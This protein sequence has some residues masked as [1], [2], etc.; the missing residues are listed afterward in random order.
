[1]KIA[2]IGA[3]GFIGSRLTEWL[4][5]REKAVVKPVVRSFSSLARLAKFDLNWSIASAD[6]EEVLT[7]ALRGCDV[8]VQAVMGQLNLIEESIA[9]TYKACVNAKVK[10]LVYLSSASVHGQNPPSATDEKSILVD[11][12]SIAYNNCKVRAERLLQK[13]AKNGET[14]IVILRPGIVFGPRDRW[15]SGIVQDLSNQQGFVVAGGRGFCN[16]IYVDNLCYAIWLAATKPDIDKETFLVGDAEVI[17]WH[18]LTCLIAE[19]LQLP[20]N[21]IWDVPPP[22]RHLSWKDRVSGMRGH[23]ATQQFLPLIPATV[24][25]YARHAMELAPTADPNSTWDL[26]YV[27][28]PIPSLE[29]AELHQCRTKLPHAKASKILGYSPIVTFSDGLRRTLEWNDWSGFR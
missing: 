22:T 29:I 24:K 16:S 13:L 12:Q 20:L 19:Y 7:A 1:M 21:Q 26:P 18:D 10:R 27:A 15:V 28:A 9:P 8:V 25:R 23:W 11:T 6:D 17:T 4:H 3:S 14:E 5:L 2:I